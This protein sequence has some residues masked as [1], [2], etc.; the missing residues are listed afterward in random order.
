MSKLP[1]CAAIDVDLT[2]TS[3]MECKWWEWMFL[4]LGY[5]P[6][7]YPHGRTT[8][9]YDLSKEIRDLGYSVRDLKPDD[10][11][12]QRDLYD[13]L[14]LPQEGSIE[15]LEYLKSWGLKICF[16]THVEGDHS[17]S[18]FKWCKKHYPFMDA[19]IPTREKWYGLPFLLIDDRHKHLNT[20]SFLPT[21][22][23]FLR[24]TPFRQEVELDRGLEFEDWNEFIIMCKSDTIQESWLNLKS[25]L[26]KVY[27]GG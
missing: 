4:M 10:F 18:K 16:V 25:K 20:C 3:G 15:A 6:E 2:L 11:W 7:V 19:F 26:E 8:L 21:E 5:I 23:R 13:D 14:I 1:L 22:H 24:H 27:L 17:K 9:D 12:K